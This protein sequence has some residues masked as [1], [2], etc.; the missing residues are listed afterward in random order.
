MR[1][2]SI[3]VVEE[4]SEPL[5]GAGLTAHPRGM[6]AV[7]PHFKGLKPRF[8]LSRFEYLNPMSGR[9]VRPDD[10]HGSFPNTAF[11]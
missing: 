2:L 1:S 3:V 10:R 9:Y 11:F 5:L 4:D 6:K 8:N 7:N